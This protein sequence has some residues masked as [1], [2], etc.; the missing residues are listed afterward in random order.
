MKQ[1]YH[2]ILL[3]ITNHSVYTG[4]KSAYVTSFNDVLTEARGNIYAD[5]TFISYVIWSPLS[6]VL[7]HLISDFISFF[8]GVYLNFL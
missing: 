3:Y 5:S 8:F 2:M 6:S 4:L 1:K 7:W